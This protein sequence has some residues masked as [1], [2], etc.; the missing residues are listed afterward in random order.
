MVIGYYGVR[1]LRYYGIIRKDFNL[2]L[3]RKNASS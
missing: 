1:V 3:F 2:G